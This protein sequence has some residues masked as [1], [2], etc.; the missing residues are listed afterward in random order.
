MHSVQ[1]LDYTAF[2]KL[3]NFPTRSENVDENIAITSENNPI[4]LPFPAAL[5][6][7]EI[8]MDGKNASSLF[9]SKLRF[10]FEDDLHQTLRRFR[11]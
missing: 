4:V 6:M 10:D 2:K 9:S 1:T 5:G 7:E 8:K 3:S 11:S